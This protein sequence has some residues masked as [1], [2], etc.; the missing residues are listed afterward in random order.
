MST[1]SQG[2]LIKY[3]GSIQEIKFKGAKPK[4][5]ELQEC[6]G[7]YI[8]CIYL[9]DGKVM[10]VNEEGKILGLPENNK[11]TSVLLTQGRYDFIVGNALIIDYKYL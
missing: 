3:D 5:T 6:V 1:K 9:N 4:L 11:A 7:G 2:T 8:E 10:V